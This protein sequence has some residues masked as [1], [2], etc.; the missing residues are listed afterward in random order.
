M[1]GTNHTIEIADSQ[2]VLKV[3]PDQLRAIVNATLDSEGVA[4]AEIS[5]ALVDNATIHD[6]NRC[7]LEHDEPTDVLSFLLECT[8]PDAANRP[9]GQGKRIEGEVIVSAEMARDTAAAYGWKPEDELVLYLVHGLLHLCGYVDS[10]EDERKVMRSRERECLQ[11]WNLTPR[12]DATSVT[13]DFAKI[14]GVG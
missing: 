2:D 14:R 10:T 7:F 5:L 11:Q 12:Y 13:G 8:P 4:E 3:E 6:L 1:T 9:G